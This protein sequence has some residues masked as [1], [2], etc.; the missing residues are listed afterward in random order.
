MQVLFESKTSREP[1]VSF[2]LLDWSCRDSFHILRFLNEQTIPREQY[3]ILWLEYYSRRA[4]QI[5]SALDERFGHGQPPPVDQWIALDIPEGICHHKHL[6]YNVGI[7]KS[8]GRI[9][10]LCDSDVLLRPTFVE[11]ILKAFAADGNIALHLDEVR[12][13]DRKFYPFNQPTVHELLG[14][15]CLNWRD[16]KTTG[17]WDTVDPLHTRN[18]GA[19][20]CARREDIIAIGGADEYIDYL[21]HICGP[22]ELTFRLVNA[23][24]REVWHQEEFLYHTWHPGTDGRG[25]H[26]GP[27]D[28]RNMSTTA[29]EIIR[30]GRIRPLVENSAIRMLRAKS[31]IAYVRPEEIL[32]PD[33]EIWRWS[34][35]RLRSVSTRTVAESLT[36]GRRFRPGVMLAALK[37]TL[38][39]VIQKIRSRMSPAGGSAPSAV[40]EKSLFDKVYLAVVFALR[41]WRNNE[42]AI[43]ACEQI[44]GRLI[45]GR[46]PAVAIYGEGPLAEVLRALLRG[47][48]VR[49]DGIYGESSLG[50]LKGYSGPVVVAALTG[51]IER[52]SALESIGIPRQNILR[53]Q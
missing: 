10:S 39:Q 45:G 17:L 11:S 29:L 51:V 7:V 36:L 31:E 24:K 16:D 19:C 35:E 43:H 30:S 27:H 40:M 25:N 44:V 38:M 37:T 6:M 47:T 4:P 46:A 23:G 15:G 12:N 26:L 1:R 2:V 13:A 34:F 52:M 49:L 42:Y 41:M 22:Y 50:G 28:G 21:G 3:E 18:Y 9:V 14:R 53:I 48:P 5:Q 32:I 20:M 8:R 33:R